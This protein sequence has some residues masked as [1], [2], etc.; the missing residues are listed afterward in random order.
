MAFVR[1]GQDSVVADYNV[2]SYK[3]LAVSTNR[4]LNDAVPSECRLWGRQFGGW[5]AGC[6]ALSSDQRAE[7][8]AG[9]GTDA[10]PPKLAS[11]LG[12]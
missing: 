10:C 9:G 8:N 5:I 6:S 11:T 4:S 1:L 3:D 7:E 2:Y 12:C